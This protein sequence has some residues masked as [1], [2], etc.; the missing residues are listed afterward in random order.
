MAR[1]RSHYFNFGDAWA[2]YTLQGDRQKD[3]VC[4]LSDCGLWQHQLDK[5]KV[6]G[7]TWEELV[8]T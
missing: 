2:V 6:C 8:V 4:K 5:D 1:E 3:C 7:T